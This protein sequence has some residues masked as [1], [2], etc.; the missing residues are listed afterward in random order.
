MRSDPLRENRNGSQKQTA[1]RIRNDSAVSEIVGTIMLISVIALGIAVFAVALFSQ[2]TAPVLPSITFDATYGENG[3]VV[4]RHL[5]GD[6]IP[7][8]R[9]RVYID[10]GTAVQDNQAFSEGDDGEN[11][12]AWGVG[13]ILVYTPPTPS[14]GAPVVPKAEILIVYADPGSGEHLVYISEGWKGPIPT[15][16]GTATSAPT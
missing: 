16:T 12:T 4:I 7:R 13:D 6:T 10:N 14:P 2:Q 15:P 5:G 3:S 1:L 8:D 9:L 11:W